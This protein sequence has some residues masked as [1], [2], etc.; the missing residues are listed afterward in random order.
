MS[1][2]RGVFEHRTSIFEG[3][4]R[5]W[6]HLG[7]LDPEDLKGIAA[8]DLDP[9]IHEIQ[10][11]PRTIHKIE[12]LYIESQRTNGVVRR[13]FPYEPLPRNGLAHPF[14][15]AIVR[16]WLGNDV[17][18]DQMQ[19]GLTTLRTWWHHRH[20][21]ESR[22]AI[23]FLGTDQMKT[24][25]KSLTSH[26]FKLLHSM[27]I[28]DKVRPPRTLYS[29]ITTRE[30]LHSRQSRK[31]PSEVQV[32]KL[33]A[34]AAKAEMKGFTPGDSYAGI[35]SKHRNTQKGRRVSF[36]EDDYSINVNENPRPPMN[37]TDNGYSL[38]NEVALFNIDPVLLEN[39]A[40]TRFQEQILEP[41]ADCHSSSHLGPNTT[42]KIL[43]LDDD[44]TLSEVAKLR[45]QLGTRVNSLS[46]TGP[47]AEYLRQ[48]LDS[49]APMEFTEDDSSSK[50]QRTCI[51]IPCPQ[52]SDPTVGI[53]DTQRLHPQDG[54]DSEYSS[55][56]AK[57]RKKVTCGLAES[58]Q[59]QIGIKIE[60]K[61]EQD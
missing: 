46:E 13:V 24:I 32:E 14:V 34:L 29:K 35:T 25:V 40:N 9:L 41:N 47:S 11:D 7:G 17:Q 58:T 61:T 60:V 4:Y 22:S 39:T 18:S 51:P 12:E 44:Q 56:V 50:N 10:D 55:L 53:E 26:F 43:D 33:A 54:D 28:L 5:A 36:R 6:S 37:S 19:L 48:M 3:S 59:S 31:R 16:S 1:R 8:K 27:V 57:Y 49:C 38:E 15:R 20:K 21:G 23:I 52:L 2:R 30:K 42:V 45:E